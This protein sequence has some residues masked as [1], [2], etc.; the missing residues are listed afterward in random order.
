MNTA[1]TDENLFS[2]EPMLGH[3]AQVLPLKLV[4][5]PGHGALICAG[6]PTKGFVQTVE[7]ILVT[8]NRNSCNQK[9]ARAGLFKAG[10]S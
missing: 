5:V 1:G 8:S 3:G 9:G 4:P 10:L 6:A 2:Q 7:R